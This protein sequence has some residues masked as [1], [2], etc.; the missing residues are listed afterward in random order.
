MSLTPEQRA[1]VEQHVGWARGIA[2]A[3]AALYRRFHDRDEL[4]GAALEGLSRAACAFDPS[5]GTSFQAFAWKWVTGAIVGEIDGEARHLGR[6][7]QRMVR[8]APEIIGEGTP[9]EATADEAIDEIDRIAAALMEDGWLHAA[10]DEQAADLV[11]RALLA[12]LKDALAA[13]EAEDRRLV[14]L[15]YFSEM[16]WRDVAQALGIPVG[17]AKDRDQRVRAVLRKKLRP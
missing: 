11:P 8:A 14:E 16:P 13:L 7:R 5:R 12:D 10:G 15:R 9:H 17:T 1:L 3:R 6:L 4:V 2:L